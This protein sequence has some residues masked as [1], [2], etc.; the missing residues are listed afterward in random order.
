MRDRAEPEAPRLLDRRSG[1]RRRIVEEL[2]AVIALGRRPAHPGPRLLRRRDVAAAPAVAERHVGEQPRRHDR[3]VAAA[4]PV[5]ERHVVRTEIER[6]AAHRGDAVGEPQPV[7]VGR[8]RRLVRIAIVA[9][10]VDE[11]GQ[12]VHAGRVDL[13]VGAARRRGPPRSGNPGVPAPLTLSIRLPAMTMSTGPRGGAPEPSISIAP[14]ITS[15]RN[16]PSP[17]PGW[18]SGTR[19]IRA[20]ASCALSA[21]TAATAAARAEAARASF[22]KPMRSPFFPAAP[23]VKPV[24]QAHSWPIQCFAPIALANLSRKAEFLK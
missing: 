14:R 1:D 5:G 12:D 22:T 10:S 6:D 20:G 9:V 13:A 8:V 24:L 3:V 16:G 4:L 18:R 21:G 2:D 17:S 19:S 15:R 23:K 7:A 11:A